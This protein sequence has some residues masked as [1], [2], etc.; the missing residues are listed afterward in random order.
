MG[1]SGRDERRGERRAARLTAPGRG[2]NRPSPQT[3]AYLVQLAAVGAVVA[4]VGAVV[5]VV[6]AAADEAAPVAELDRDLAGGRCG[7]WDILKYL[8]T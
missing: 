5:A 2:P 7:R 8:N 3:H 1:R 6:V 4:A